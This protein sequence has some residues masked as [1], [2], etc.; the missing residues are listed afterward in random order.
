[1]LS[2]E[3]KRNGG[4]SFVDDDGGVGNTV[5]FTEGA[6]GRG[7]HC[8]EELHGGRDNDGRAPSLS[9]GPCFDV[10]EFCPVMVS[11]D[12]ALRV[13]AGQH[14]GGA[15]ARD[16]LVDQIGEREDDEN[17]VKATVDSDSQCVGGKSG[18]FPGAH[19]SVAPDYAFNERRCGAVLKER[20]T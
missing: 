17:P 4:V 14:E 9:E 7:G 19:G 11:E 8:L 16:G 1:V 6:G 3:L 18:G 5:K 12:N 2:P 20:G 15:Q 13:F 10:G